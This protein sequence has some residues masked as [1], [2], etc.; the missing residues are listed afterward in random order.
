MTKSPLT[1]DHSPRACRVFAVLLP[2]LRTR[3]LCMHQ[4]SPFQCPHGQPRLPRRR[5]WNRKPS[6]K[7]L[8]STV[9]MPGPILPPY[10][11]S[12]EENRLCSFSVKPALNVTRLMGVTIDAWV[13]VSKNG[14]HFF[15]G[16]RR[17][18]LLRNATQLLTFSDVFVTKN[19]PRYAFMLFFEPKRPLHVA[20]ERPEK[21]VVE[22]TLEH[23]GPIICDRHVHK[24]I[25]NLG[26]AIPMGW[27]APAVVLEVLRQGRNH[28]ADGLWREMGSPMRNQAILTM[29][30]SLKSD[31]FNV[32]AMAAPAQDFVEANFPCSHAHGS[33]A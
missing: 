24:L 12:N 8:A 31:F 17:P 33:M 32:V 26:R 11:Q 21:V 10:A 2:T 6:P 14:V 1:Q 15:G 29:P 7:M 3:P 4:P 16:V 28:A 20:I 30:I 25:R 23:G 19:Y 13:E 27:V 22:V 18:D 9:Q 5:L